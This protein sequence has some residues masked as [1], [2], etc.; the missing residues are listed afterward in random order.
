MRKLLKIKMKNKNLILIIQVFII[1]M[2]K[3]KNG[4][5][6]FRILNNHFKEIIFLKN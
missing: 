1:F 5:K 4:H 2:K 3:C 6:C